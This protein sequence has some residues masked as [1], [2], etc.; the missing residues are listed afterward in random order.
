ML[1][2]FSSFIIRLVAGAV[3]ELEEAPYTVVAEH[4]GWEERDYPPTRWVSTDAFDMFV[5]DGPEYSKVS[6]ST[7]MQ[8][9]Y[10]HFLGILVLL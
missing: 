2:S 6:I 10:I 8:N 7:S 5:H 4:E 3:R 9:C 1:F